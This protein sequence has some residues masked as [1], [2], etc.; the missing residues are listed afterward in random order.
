MGW[1]HTHKPH[2]QSMR[3]FFIAQGVLR[4]TSSERYD[5]R[6]LDTSTVARKAFYAA[7]EETERETGERKVYALIVLLR[8]TRG[9]DDYNLLY[10]DM[11]ESM[12]PLEAECP[13]RILKLL[14]PTENI[15]A[16]DWRR[17]CQEK[18]DARRAAK[19]H[20][21]GDIVEYGANTYRLTQNLGRRGWEVQHL[22]TGAVYR[23]RAAQLINA[24]PYQEAS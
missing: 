17:R 10:K 12:G 5:F 1:M 3:D 2:G 21:P 15:H 23:M 14:T 18:I 6:V 13:E 19:A 4:W 8:W 7:I 9:P 24:T 20:K 11:D 16:Q 22:K